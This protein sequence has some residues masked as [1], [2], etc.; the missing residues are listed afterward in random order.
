MG[1]SKQAPDCSDSSIST[2]SSSPSPLP[3][4]EETFTSSQNDYPPM[5]PLNYEYEEHIPGQQCQH[6]NQY[7]SQ[8]DEYPIAVPYL[9][10][11]HTQQQDIAETP[12]QNV[13]EEQEFIEPPP[14]TEQ[15][16]ASAPPK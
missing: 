3:D 11:L 13:R 1:C 6:A 8:L 15:P 5:E 14:Y 10:S 2:E 16:E 9:P 4:Q 7:L 12:L